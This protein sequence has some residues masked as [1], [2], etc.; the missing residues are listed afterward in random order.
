M[1]KKQIKNYLKT[2]ILLLGISLLLWNCE[3]EVPIEPLNEELNL[4]G[5]KIGYITGEDIPEV[6]NVLTS[7]TGKTSSKKAIYSKT[8]SYKKA[9]IDIESILKVKDYNSIINYSF[10]III[11]DAPENEFYNLV[12]NEQPNGE[13]KSPYVTKYVVDNDALGDY[14]ANNKDFRYFKGKNYTM[15]FNSFF[16]NY[17][18]SGKSLSDC[19]PDETTINN[20]NTGE[21]GNFN[22]IPSDNFIQVD[23]S[24]FNYSTSVIQG[25][26]FEVFLN[27]F[28]ITTLETTSYSA[29]IMNTVIPIT[30]TVQPINPI[31]VNTNLGI[32]PNSGPVIIGMSI[33][34]VENSN[35]GV[36]SGC[37]MTIVTYYS[38]G[39]STTS[40]TDIDC[41]YAPILT[42][43]AFSSKTNTC[44]DPA[45]GEIGVI[46]RAC[47]YP[48]VK[49]AQGNCMK[50]DQIINEL[51]G[52]AKC[53]YGKMVDNNNNI[54]WILENFEDGNTPSRFN[55]K[56]VMSTTLSDS[57]NASFA[58]PLQS[59]ITNTFVISI[60]AN[61][62]NNRTS[63]GLARTIIHEGIHARLWEF[64]YSRDKD[65]AI[66]S[67]D[68]PGIYDFYKNY[69]QNWD[70][71][72][73]AAYYRE[74]IAQGL[75]QYDNGQ[76]TDAFY[77][78][79]AWEG[80]SEIKDAN[81]NHEM[82]YTEAWNKLTLTEQTAILQ[83]ITNEKQ[84][85]SKECQ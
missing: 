73:M 22:D 69:Q 52:K 29:I 50:V 19:P 59:G 78:A 24:N 44:P 56:F 82:I 63:L 39:T 40:Q 30:T 48:Y 77:N 34:T 74:T 31:T 83:I 20:T 58:T 28:N 18:T 70:H 6:I 75:K 85:G 14:L 12:I 51:T 26:S 76:H 27:S 57:T 1:K 4:S 66:I 2:G 25:Q 61:T 53:V 9:R 21:N 47:E 8:L 7:F 23:P 11:D 16:D 10:N 43:P 38:D 32:V 60:N 37:Y 54:N 33:T 5:T 55:L 36:S 84:N 46:I 64:M 41:M 81:N 3:K 49:D 71:E 42:K 68:F 65:L 15:S 17:D 80:L 72:Q 13:L 62:I 35:S 67:N 45:E 79:L